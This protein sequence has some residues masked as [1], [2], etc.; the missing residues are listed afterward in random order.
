MEMIEW[1]K[2]VIVKFGVVI[3]LFDDFCCFY[4]WLLMLELDVEWMVVWVMWVGVELMLDR[5]SVV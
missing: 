1:G 4:I 3:S 5:K 2:M